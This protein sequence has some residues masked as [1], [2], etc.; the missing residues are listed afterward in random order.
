VQHYIKRNGV[1]PVP[2]FI[3]SLNNYWGAGELKQIA[4]PLFLKLGR[5]LK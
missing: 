3:A 2:Q 4:F 5:I 1:D